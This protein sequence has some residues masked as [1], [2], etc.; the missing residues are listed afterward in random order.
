MVGLVREGGF[1][2]VGSKVSLTLK[3][4]VVSYRLDLSFH[5]EVS[6]I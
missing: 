2:S 5:D 3:T 6:R 1:E 4:L